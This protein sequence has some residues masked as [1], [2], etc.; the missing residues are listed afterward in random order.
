MHMMVANSSKME[1][2][3][4]SSLPDRRPRRPRRRLSSSCFFLLTLVIREL[5][6]KGKLPKNA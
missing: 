3:L 4:G 1:R 2:E 5:T 6:R